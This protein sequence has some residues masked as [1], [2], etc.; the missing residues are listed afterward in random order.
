MIYKA[1]TLFNTLKQD[2]LNQKILNIKNIQI[3]NFFNINFSLQWEFCHQFLELYQDWILN[4]Q[5]YFAYENKDIQITKDDIVFDCGA[6]MGLFAAYAASKGAQVYCFEPCSFTRSLLQQTQNLYPNNITIVPKALT[7]QNG[8][9]TLF[10]TS[11]IG[12]NRLKTSNMAGEITNSTEVIE[13]I[14]L[15]TFI[16]NNKIYPTFIKIDIEGSEENMLKGFTTINKY[17]PKIAIASYHTSRDKYF[18][19]QYFDFLNYQFLEEKADILFFKV[20]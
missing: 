18:F 15:D 1:L 11:N 3:P 4:P 14:T 13:T 10:L 19:K 16:E 6:N 17:C 12:A 5:G 2:I 7:D 9:D 20:R 8:T